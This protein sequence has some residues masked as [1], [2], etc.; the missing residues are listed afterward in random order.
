MCRLRPLPLASRGWPSREG[1]GPRSP[2]TPHE[3]ATGLRTSRTS[4]SAPEPGDQSVAPPARRPAERLSATS[5]PGH[6]ARIGREPGDSAGSTA[7]GAAAATADGASGDLSGRQPG[8]PCDMSYDSRDMSAAQKEPTLRCPSCGHGLYTVDQ[9]ARLTGQSTRTLQRRLEAS[10]LSGAIREPV[11]GGFRWLVPLEAVKAASPRPSPHC[12]RSSS[13]RS[14]PHGP[15]WP[16]SSRH[17]AG[18]PADRR[19]SRR[20]PQ[21]RRYSARSSDRPIRA[22]GSPSFRAG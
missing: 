3:L 21:R 11:P 18:A 1:A 12:W 19:R 20:A 4:R 8:A 10:E 5:I 22:T 2:I 17:S 15:P 14:R 13:P 16:T 7:G 6:R 9:V